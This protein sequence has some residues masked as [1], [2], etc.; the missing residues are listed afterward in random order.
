MSLAQ[1]LEQTPVWPHTAARVLVRHGAAIGIEIGSN[2]RLR[3]RV[4]E[5]TAA[6]GDAAGAF[7]LTEALDAAPLDAHA[8]SRVLWL[9]TRLLARAPGTTAPPMPAAGLDRLRWLVLAAERA[10]LTGEIAVASGCWREAV[11]LGEA[12]AAGP[13][14]HPDDA[15]EVDELTYEAA[16]HTIPLASDADPR[17]ARRWLD[18]ATALAR[19][20]RAPHEE[21]ALQW[22]AMILLFRLGDLSALV[23]LAA[24][25]RELPTDV[26]GA[27]S[28]DVRAQLDAMGLARARDLEGA[29][30]ALDQAIE[31]AH[32]RR[33]VTAYLSLVTSKI[34]VFDAIGDGYAAYRSITLARA[35]LR[36]VTGDDVGLEPLRAELQTRWA[37]DWDGYA[38]RLKAELERA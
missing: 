13:H 32:G 29:V 31:E 28:P 16:T 4:A 10:T 23:A 14:R 7:R 15:R 2:L 1:T 22:L 20:W 19:R 6:A 35:W 5:L 34:R 36:R 25:A 11:T 33:D 24:R 26:P 30:G 9:K 27:L 37:A 21:A 3:L 8:R 17:A 12:L 38:P 18:L